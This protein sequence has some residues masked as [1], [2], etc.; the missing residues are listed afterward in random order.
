LNPKEIKLD[1]WSEEKLSNSKDIQYRGFGVSNVFEYTKM[2][3]LRLCLDM[4]I[5]TEELL[6]SVHKAIKNY[7]PFMRKHC[8]AKKRTQ[9]GVYEHY[10]EIYDLKSQGKTTDAIAK[11]IF[12]E[13][14]AELKQI[15]RNK[16]DIDPLRDRISKTLKACK[17]LIGGDYKKIK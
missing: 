1:A 6:R 13:E 9:L 14:Y 17:K 3:T 10:L 5:S 2:K 12:P 8:K 4:T 7:K 11:Q 15:P 16:Y